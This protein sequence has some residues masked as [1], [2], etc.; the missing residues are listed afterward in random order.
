MK[1][2]LQPQTIKMTNVDN[3]IQIEKEIHKHGN[4]LPI[5]IHGIICGTSN[6]DKINVLISFLESLHGILLRPCHADSV[7]RR[8]QNTEDRGNASLSVIQQD[9]Q[10]LDVSC[11]RVRTFSRDLYSLCSVFSVLHQ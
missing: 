3:K 6:C 11:R 7:D 4:M 10:I 8:S 5:S 2:V 1:F 9:R